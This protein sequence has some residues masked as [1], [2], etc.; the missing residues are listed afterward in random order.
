MNGAGSRRLANG[1][2]YAEG[3]AGWGNREQRRQ[4]LRVTFARQA[5]QN[6]AAMRARGVRGAALRSAALRAAAGSEG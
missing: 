5:R 3:R 2:R 6:V 4:D 1:G